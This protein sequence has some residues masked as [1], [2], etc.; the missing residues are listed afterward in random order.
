MYPGTYAATRPNHPALIMA[1]SGEIVTYAALEARTNRLAHLLRA[2]GLRR[3]DHYAISMENH[4]RYVE[5]L[6][7]RRTGRP[8]LYLHQLVSYRRRSRLHRQQQRIEAADHLAGQA[9]GRPRRAGAMPQR[10]T[11]PH[12]GR[13]R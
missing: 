13:S 11:L 2:A 10:H 9:R 6:R 5:T 4:V 12:R 3:L 1:A 8:L 7:C